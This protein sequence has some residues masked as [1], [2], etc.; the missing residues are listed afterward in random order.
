[1]T[2]D[3]VVALCVIGAAVVVYLFRDVLKMLVLYAVI[4]AAVAA[5]V[6][7]IHGLGQVLAIAALPL[8]WFGWVLLF[9][10]ASC[11]VC[12]GKG[13]FTA[14]PYHR[15]CPKC[16]GGKSKQR[17]TARLLG[18][19]NPRQPGSLIAPKTRNKYH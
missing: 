19:G 15:L 13:F 14:G 1:M 16:N 3:Q 18:R 10:Y 6:T 12:K 2:H 4:A 9:P 7:H 5:A 17:V 8:A 11:R